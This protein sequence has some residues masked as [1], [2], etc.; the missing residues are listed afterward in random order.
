[1]TYRT[2]HTSGYILNI[3]A[4]NQDQP[5][6]KTRGGEGCEGLKP[7]VPMSSFH[8]IRTHHPPDTLMC[9]LTRKFPPRNSG[10]TSDKLFIM[11]NKVVDGI[12]F[13]ATHQPILLSD[14]THGASSQVMD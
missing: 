3:K 10:Q 11:E 14:T 8:G 9:S 5:N 13:P 4:T 1:M 7:R 6:E 2:R 12:V